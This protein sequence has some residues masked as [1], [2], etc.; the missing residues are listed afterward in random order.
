MTR[1]DL[2]ER[3]SRRTRLSGSLAA[4]LVEKIFECLEQA[5]RRGDKIELRG[6][7]SF[8]VRSYGA[9]TGRNPRS[10]QAIAVGPKRLPYF[11]PSKEIA[12]RVNEGRR[13]K[14][15]DGGET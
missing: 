1:A 8:Q 12:E 3:V 14:I 5:L 6:F 11:R 13:R 2:I 4:L 9:Y 15:A 10:G 7:G